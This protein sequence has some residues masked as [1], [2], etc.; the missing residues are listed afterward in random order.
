MLENRSKMNRRTHVSGVRY[1]AGHIPQGRRLGGVSHSHRLKALTVLAPRIAGPQPSD[2][3]LGSTSS[4][5]VAERVGTSTLPLRLPIY[6]LANTGLCW[7]T[8]DS[9]ATFAQVRR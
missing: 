7:T 1:A 9:E 3:R 6:G 4:S 5:W 2:K 8:P